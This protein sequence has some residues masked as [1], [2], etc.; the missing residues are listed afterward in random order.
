MHEMSLAESVLE[1][2]EDSAR[3]QDFRRVRRVVLEIGELAAVEPDAMRF[4]FDAVMRGTLA[5]GAE[6][7][8]VETPGAGRCGQCGA[9]VAMQERYGLC[10]DCGSAALQVTVGERMRVQDLLVE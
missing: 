6:L 2:I 9:T 10:P 5:E 3:A 8:I 7:Q 1:I 4:C